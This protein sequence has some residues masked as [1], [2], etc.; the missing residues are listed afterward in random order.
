MRASAQVAYAHWRDHATLASDFA[1]DVQAVM[2]GAR[3]RWRALCNAVPCTW[4]TVCTADVPGRLLTW[5][6]VTS[7]YARHSWDLWFAERAD[8]WGT[9]I[10]L[11]VVLDAA[12][13][14]PP[15]THHPVGNPSPSLHLEP[16]ES[17]AIHDPLLDPD[18]ERALDRLIALWQTRLA[19]SP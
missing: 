9:D 3:T 12:D 17:G 4:E 13:I 5:T 6:T 15:A 2:Y 8:G 18:P 10:E 7:E 16:T 11:V 14:Q 1:P 19:L